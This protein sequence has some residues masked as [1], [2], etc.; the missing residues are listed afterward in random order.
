MNM[1]GFD[2]EASL[3]PTRGIYR[4]SADFG[5]LGTG[6]V[7]MQQFGASSF[8]GRFGVTIRC[9]RYSTFLHRYVCIERTVSPF[10]QCE[11]TGG[12]FG[13]IIICHPPIL[14]P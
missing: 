11:C 7:S 3:G 5:G 8:A 1:P 14:L 9:C 13:P 10:E 2:A 4:G 6:E 12:G